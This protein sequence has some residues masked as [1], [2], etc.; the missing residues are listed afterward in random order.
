[1]ADRHGHRSMHGLGWKQ[2]ASTRIMLRPRIMVNERFVVLHNPWG[3]SPSTIEG[4]LLVTGIW[5]PGTTEV[6]L[7]LKGLC[8]WTDW[9]DAPLPRYWVNR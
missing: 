5:K 1:M 2:T 8:A 6:R 7:G 3:S 4:G 9:F